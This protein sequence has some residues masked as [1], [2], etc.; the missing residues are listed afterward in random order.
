MKLIE[1]RS[2]R[3]FTLREK[4]EEHF[5]SEVEVRGKLYPGVVFESHGRYHEIDSEKKGVVLIF[6]QK[7]GRI[8]ENPLQSDKGR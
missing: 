2:M 3:L 1:K 4:F 6:D 7:T 8:V 5:P